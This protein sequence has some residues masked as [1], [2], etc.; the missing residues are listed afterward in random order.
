MAMG[1]STFNPRQ[2]MA[3]FMI[4]LLS[5]VAILTSCGSPTHNESSIPYGGSITI[6]PSPVG[7]FNCSFNPFESASSF[8]TNCYGVNGLIYESLIYTDQLTG[9]TESWLAKSFNWSNNAQ[10]LTL[11]L[12][13]HALWSDGQPF[14]SADVVYTF[15]ILHRFPALDKYKIW[16]QLTS[17]TAS[18]A[19][20][21]IMKFAAP[22]LVLQWFVGVKT[23]IVPQHIWKDIPDP[24]TAK[25][26]HPI[27]T[28]PFLLQSFSP[29]LYTFKRNSQYWQP[30]KPYIDEVRFPSYESNTG[31]TV[32]LAQGTVDWTG[33][34][35]DSVDKSYVMLDPTHNH[36]WFPPTAMVALG[37]NL[38]RKPFQSVAV[39]Q[40]ISLAINRDAIAS[41]AEG[42]YVPAFS[43]TGIVLPGFE[44]YLD[45][46]YAQLT[47][48]MDISKAKELL[49]QAGYHVGSDGVLVNGEGDRLAFTLSTV[50][51]WTDWIKASQLIATQLQAVNI[52]VEVQTFPYSDFFQQE[53]LGT[54]DLAII[55]TSSYQGPSPFYY[56]NSIL[57]SQLTAPIGQQAL[58]NWI[59]WNDPE[60]DRLL[61]NYQEATGDA[62]QKEAILGLQKIMVEQF[63]ILPL[64]ASF[65][66]S[67]YSTARFVGWPDASHPYALP[68]PYS[69]PDIERILIS[70]HRP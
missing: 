11:K 17:I 21:V 2:W 54:F 40:A 58:S 20:T 49:A 69:S 22:S 4:F 66:K 25:L 57:N 56:L 59:R 5:S 53:Q 34:F 68:S 43:P 64:F 62:A 1:F 31:T 7:K 32:L 46:K 45:P 27:G 63:P 48:Q 3:A 15:D 42:G 55:S 52:A 23:F 65:P 70:V 8:T 35:I 37:L 39:R 12:Q 67:E 13:P 44:S 24:S 18:D 26:S 38:A 30:G 29:D 6:V 14:T 36:Y 19:T 47:Y 10:A 16:D 28:G 51:G 61:K 41:Q 9:Q 50:D 60:T 33:V